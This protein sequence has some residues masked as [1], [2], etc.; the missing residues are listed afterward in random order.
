MS[1]KD[2][3]L[4]APDPWPARRA[5]SLASIATVITLLVVCFGV[6]PVS[7]GPSGL[8]AQ[9]A[10]S[11][12]HPLIL[13]ENVAGIPADM[14]AAGPMRPLFNLNAAESKVVFRFAIAFCLGAGIGFATYRRVNERQPNRLNATFISGATYADGLNAKSKTAFLLGSDYK[15][16]GSGIA[17]APDLRLPRNR[18]IQSLLV[19]G[20]PRYGKSTALRFMLDGILARRGDKLIVYDSKGDVT[21]D[22]PGS[23][24]ILLAPHDTRSWGWA[25]GRDVLGEPGAREFAAALIPVSDREPNWALGG[26]EILIAAIRKLQAT[27]DTRW[28]WRELGELLDLPDQELRRVAHDHHR[29]ALRYLTLDPETHEFDRTAASYVSTA[30]APIQRIVRP[31]AQAWSD[32]AAEYQVSL[33]TW[34]ADE[35]PAHRTIILQRAAHLPAVSAAWI[36]AALEVMAR[37]CVGPA[38][39]DDEDRRLWFVL[40]EFSTVPKIEGLPD[41]FAQGPSKGV[42]VVLACQN[43]ELVEDRYGPTVTKSIIQNTDVQLLFRLNAGETS[44]YLTKTAIPKTEIR[45]YDRPR[46]KG[47]NDAATTPEKSESICLITTHDLATLPRGEAYAVVEGS[48]VRLRWPRS[49]WTQQREPTIQA[50]WVIDQGTVKLA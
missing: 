37:F 7:E 28:S 19:V 47:P 49:T 30:M 9:L 43:L 44:T 34:L 42:C 8:A 29:A 5:A 39:A 27:L 40:D 16:S 31:L 20:R 35:Q 26:Q 36:T 14:T 13:L 45:R 11:F 25:V 38:L 17:L 3:P 22:W 50:N 23:K 18:E 15:A 21:A 24:V 1:I 10:W 2:Q 4:L 6:F 33:R 46:P 12:G 48:V 41:L 32:L